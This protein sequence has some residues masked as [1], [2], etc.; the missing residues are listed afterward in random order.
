MNSYVPSFARL[1]SRLPIR[2]PYQRPSVSEMCQIRFWRHKKSSTRID[3]S[4]CCQRADGEGFEPPV[5]CGTPVFKT[6]AF[7]HSATRPSLYFPAFE[8]LFGLAG[9][10]FTS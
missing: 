7:D 4:R 9:H 1:R 2:T 5:P 3:V 6:G 10:Y 8:A